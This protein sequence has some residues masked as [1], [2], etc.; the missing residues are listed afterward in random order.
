[1]TR[2]HRTLIYLLNLE[3]R[4]RM[5]ENIGPGAW[6]AI[7]YAVGEQQSKRTQSGEQQLKRTQSGAAVEADTIG[8][9][10]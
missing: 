5:F 10:S 6:A 3:L 1:M 8:S 4:E 2:D 9:S 7:Q